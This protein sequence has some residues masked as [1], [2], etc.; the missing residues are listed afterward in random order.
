MM[1]QKAVRSALLLLALS[2]TI[3]ACSPN[4][5]SHSPQT[6]SANSTDGSGTILS[7]EVTQK[8]SLKIASITDDKGRVVTDSELA[9]MAGESLAGALAQ[10]RSADRAVVSRE[11]VQ[12]D[13]AVAERVVVDLRDKA[14][15][16]IQLHGDASLQQLT[17]ASSRAAFPASKVDAALTKGKISQMLFRLDNGRL[18]VVVAFGA[19]QKQEEAKQEAPKQE[20]AKQEAPKQEE[21]KQEAPKQEEAKQEMPKQ[22]E[23]KQEMPKQEE[24]KQE[25]PKQEE[26]KQEM[27]KQEEAKQEM[28]KQEEAKQEEAKQESP[29]QEEAKQE[30][31]KQEEA[32]QEAKQEAPKQ[33]GRY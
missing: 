13:G 2:G 33:A 6:P 11:A 12:L 32:K 4:S 18:N 31:P 5:G 8:A 17:V 25:M 1:N 7:Q 30:S 27:P 14:G 28:P 23:A 24:A 21:A 29:K 16:I 19:E 15:S 22:E 9:T 26:A 10:L 20:E 3:A